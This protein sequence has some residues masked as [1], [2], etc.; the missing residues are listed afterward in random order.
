MEAPD[1]EL[2]SDSGERV[3]LSDLRGKPVV[4]YFYPR[5]DTRAT[6]CSNPRSALP[7]HVRSR[8]SWATHWRL[9][10]AARAIADSD[11]PSA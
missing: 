5:D 7:L 8:T 3:R 2:A 4:L 11:A 10:P 6:F 9:T 1:F